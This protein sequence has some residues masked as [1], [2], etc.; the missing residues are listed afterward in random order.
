[1]SARAL[2]RKRKVSAVA[3]RP[4][5]P[6]TEDATEKVTEGD[7]IATPETSTDEPA[8]TVEISGPSDAPFVM[9]EEPD[10]TLEEAPSD[11]EVPS[12]S[13]APSETVDADP[14]ASGATSE[15]VPPE[16]DPVTTP[17]AVST[18][19]QPVQV[20][21]GPGFVPLVL[22]G[23]VAGAIGYGVASYLP[24]AEPLVDGDLTAR[25]EANESGLASLSERVDTLPEPQ[26]TD[27]SDIDARVGEIEA[28]LIEAAGDDSTDALDGRLTSLE[29]ALAG[30]ENRLAA[31]EET[32]A[33]NTGPGA[34][35]GAAEDQLADF[36]AEL[37]ALAADAEARI[38]EANSRASQ[39]EADAADAAARAERQAALSQLRTAVE[40]G[41]P[42]ADALSQFAD[43][44][45]PLTSAAETGVPTLTQLQQTF[46][47]AARDALAAVQTVPQ[48]ASAGDRFVAFLKR[49][50]NAR[51]L[52]PKQGDDPDAVL[53]RAEAALNEGR[54]A[55]T[56]T[57][58]DALP[59]E[60][61]EA[62]NDWLTQARARTGALAALDDLSAMTN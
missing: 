7:A 2:P 20:Q 9:H 34:L 10:R 21:R 55:D 3:R 18:P 45:E 4:K 54:L 5:T 41:A 28:R 35:E 39:I 40:G 43:A 27:L 14:V 59:P 19:P 61:Q 60:V 53:S 25:L 13:V 8:E 11:Q 47:E 50:T 31:L 48:D 30:L 44:P 12:D 62:M 6:R 1:M 38:E 16:P 22:G 42:F 32:V 51:S 33:Q 56:L 23:L 46:P 58:L 17:L 24:P 15:D 29:D 57:V 52:A 26:V 49:Q 37:D 36:R